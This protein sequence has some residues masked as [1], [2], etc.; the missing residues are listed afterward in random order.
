MVAGSL[1]NADVFRAVADPIRRSILDYLR[2]GAKPVH[3]LASE[4]PVSRPAI[5]K[6]LRILRN[7]H[8][9][10]EER[11]GRLRLYQLNAAPLSEVEQWVSEYRIFWKKSLKNLKAY[12]EGRPQAKHPEGR[13]IKK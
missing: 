3:Q 12:V 13:K 7:S 4:F 8:L 5:S 6:H 2:T 10:T 9:V 11:R 1:R